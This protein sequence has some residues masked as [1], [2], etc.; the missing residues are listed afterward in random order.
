MSIFVDKKVDASKLSDGCLVAAICTALF[1]GIYEYFSFG[2]FSFYM[3]YAFAFLLV[4]G[5]MF[6]KLVGK[7]HALIP[8]GTACLW[9]A[10]LATLTI[11]SLIKGVLDIY[12]SSNKL[13]WIFLIIGL[14]DLLLALLI[15][16]GSQK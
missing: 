15:G 3:I 6:W 10:G 2:V 7:R 14:I 12:G 1:G 5:C 8:S 16:F 13:V 11:G 9:G 4:G